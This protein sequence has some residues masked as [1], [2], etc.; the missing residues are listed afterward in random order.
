MPR[1]VTETGTHHINID[2][3]AHIAGD[4]SIS[5]GYL[6][7]NEINDPIQLINAGLLYTKESDG[8][9]ELHFRNDS[10][11]T[12]QLTSKG[13]ILLGSYSVDDLPSPYPAGQ[14]IY[15]IDDT[16]GAVPA[17]SDGDDWRRVTDRAVV[18]SGS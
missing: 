17:F 2:G 1:H 7:L 5:D 16:G 3:Y 6:T 9:S 12:A 15:V 14:M 10:G 11:N 18:S 4:V 13:H 8:Y